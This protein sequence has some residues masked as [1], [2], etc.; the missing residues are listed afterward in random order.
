MRRRA[1][2]SDPLPRGEALLSALADAAMPAIAARDVAIVVAH[3][4]DE[5]IGCGAQLP[6][7]RGA[8]LIVLTDGA[9][10]NA[11]GARAHGFAT[12][13]AYAKCRARELADALDIAGNPLLRV[14]SLGVPD[15]QAACAMGLITR[16]LTTLFA[17]AGITVAITHAYEAGH[18]DHDAAAFVVHAAAAALRRAG[19]RLDIVEMP[20]YRLG[21]RGVVYQ[22]FAF[23]W[24]QQEI[25]A[26]T[27]EQSSRKLRM[28]RAHASQARVLAPFAVDA[29]RFRIA[30]HYDFSRLP[31]AGRLLY[32]RHDL[33]MSG[34][35]WTA[36]ARRA[37]ARNA[38]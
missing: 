25:V 22:R 24:P 37:L 30:P 2:L 9:P 14:A 27:P 16:R 13:E 7:L 17:R 29:E 8:L 23:P 18:P 11:I 36:L 33:G 1:A 28:L 3:P 34:V 15:Q 35:R 4:D 21:P 31:N 5:T 38:A 19:R 26:L 6:R 10:R 32:E 20:F 12:A